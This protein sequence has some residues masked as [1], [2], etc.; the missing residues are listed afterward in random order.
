[1]GRLTGLSSF[2]SSSSSSSMHALYLRLLVA[3]DLE[4]VLGQLLAGEGLGLGLAV[5]L[6]DLLRGLLEDHLDVAGA[7][8]VGVDT[9]VGPVG[10][11][12]ALLSTVD[13]D[14]SDGQGL[15]VQLLEL[16]VALGV[17]EQAQ[18]HLHGLHGPASL[19]HLELLGL[20]G[21][22]DAAS[23]HSEG[24]AALL[25]KDLAQVL[26]GR[27]EGHALDGPAGLVGV[28]VVHP[29]V[30]THGLAG[31]AGV[32]GFGAISNHGG[33]DAVTNTKF[34]G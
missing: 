34:I 10:A 6:L 17:L 23:V 14:V 13:L 9:T 28:L 15:R 27:G 2:S 1:M 33:E 32:F 7:V 31:L 26:L 12:A 25:V 21:L 5:R 18:D 4:A 20:G 24:D 19:G 16:G 3:T 30:G 22:A 8:Q 29:E 11:T